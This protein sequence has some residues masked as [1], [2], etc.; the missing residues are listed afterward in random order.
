MSLKYSDSDDIFI[1]KN[2]LSRSKITKKTS[3]KIIKK[4]SKK[5]IKKLSKKPSK[6]NTKKTSKKITKK[7]SKKTK[8][9]IKKGGSNKELESPE[10]SS[11]EDTV[12]KGPDVCI[13]KSDGISCMTTDQIKFMV[14]AWNK[15]SQKHN[16]PQV[17][18]LNMKN[19]SEEEYRK[20]AIQ[21]LTKIFGDKCNTQQCWANQ[22]FLDE[23]SDKYQDEVTKL[24]ELTWRPSGPP[25]AAWLNT[26]HINNVLSQEEKIYNNFIL[27]GTYPYDYTNANSRLKN[28]NLILKLIKEKLQKEN[29]IILGMVLNTDC[30]TGS[31]QHWVCIVVE[32]NFNNN[33]QLQKSYFLYFDSYGNSSN[34]NRQLSK[35][36]EN[37]VYKFYN[38]LKDEVLSDLGAEPNMLE[39]K[40]NKN[41]HQYCNTECGVYCINT[42]MTILKDKDFIGGETF[43]KKRIT[44]E[45]MIDFRFNIFSDN[46]IENKKK[47]KQAYSDSQ[48]PLEKFN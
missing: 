26:T 43:N 30:S 12:D 28:K 38:L 2:K 9:V 19:L 11:F 45:Q 34:L 22:K 39:F 15:Y 47:Y 17:G 16:L 10:S 4:A 21:E 23:L 13:F 33:K 25:G 5:L 46:G 3:K 6:K 27:L 37:Y 8:K 40:Y 20:K 42:I 32:L 31:G 35:C 1:K 14:L 7:T 48:C 24:R 29:R 41:R 36:G 44:D 18:G